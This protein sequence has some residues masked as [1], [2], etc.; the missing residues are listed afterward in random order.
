M[1][2]SLPGL[3]AIGDCSSPIMLAHVASREGEIAAENIM[4]HS[5]KMDY[6]RV[7]GAIYTNPEIGWVGLTEKQALEKGCKINVGRFPMAFNGKSMVMGAEGFFK[8]I[9]DQRLGE[10]LGIHLVG[11]RATDLIGEAVLAMGMEATVDDLTGVIRAHPTI[12]EA[13]GEAA[14]DTMGRSLGKV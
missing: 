8:V 7:P 4:G 10:I 11:P 9:V 5:V 3:W 2:S 12:N 14:L 6:R 13:L 1:A